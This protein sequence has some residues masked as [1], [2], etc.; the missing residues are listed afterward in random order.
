MALVR[1]L[2]KRQINKVS[3]ICP[4]YNEELIIESAV[5]KLLGNLSKLNYQWE[6]VLVNDG[7]TDKSFEIVKEVVN[8]LDNV[9]LISYPLNR[10]RGYALNKGIN[11]SSGDI[12]A[13]TEIDLSWGDD[14]IQKIVNKFEQEPYWDC[15]VVSPNLSE[16]GYK[17]VPLRRVLISK[18]GN[19]II[20]SFFTKKVTMNTG[21]TRGYRK[22]IIQNLPILEEGKEFHLEVLLKLITLGYKITEIPTILEWKDSKF[23]K[24]GNMTRKSSS[25]ISKLIV[26]HLNFAVFANPIRYFWAM[27]L[28]CGLI[29]FGFICNAFYRL[30]AGKV[31]IYIASVGF[32]MIIVAL[33]FFGFGIVSNQN[34]YI[35]RELWILQKLRKNNK[36]TDL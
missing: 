1:E 10:G 32:S 2:E 6:L 21:M 27:A 15:V 23:I 33:L 35:L 24:K 31:A 7:S 4:Y 3:V 25:K 8:R 12:I 18:I 16:G 22:D 28:V 20:R 36:Q 5:K 19:S 30:M 26:S 13:T 11:A 29:G 17:N 9:I 14:I 34:N